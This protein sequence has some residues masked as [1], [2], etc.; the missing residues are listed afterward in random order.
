MPFKKG[1]TIRIGTRHSDGTKK[2]ISESRHRIYRDVGHPCSG[3][4]LSFET[5]QKIS[6]ARK[7][8]KM[9][10]EN[11]KRLS[12]VVAR[13]E[14]H[15]N[16]KGGKTN[17]NKAIRGSVEYKL[18][19]D[20]VFKRDNFTCVCC[21]KCGGDLNADHIKPFAYYVELRFDISNGRTLC[22]PCHRKTFKDICHHKNLVCLRSR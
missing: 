20:S 18:W 22:I 2:A 12:Q 5:K 7:G 19:R 4:R 9:S 6:N 11:R 21:G 3:K 1:N 15:H 16:W 10:E 17:I 14:K 13:G 8:A